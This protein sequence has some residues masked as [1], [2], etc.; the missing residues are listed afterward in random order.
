ME[1][2]GKLIENPHYI[3]PIIALSKEEWDVI[4]KVVERVQYKE[5][6]SSKFER[7]CK[8]KRDMREL[9]NLESSIKR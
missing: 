8:P 3:Q 6:R 4:Y 1:R 9:K 7:P 2:V 5:P